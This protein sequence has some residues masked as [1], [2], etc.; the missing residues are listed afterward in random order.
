MRELERRADVSARRRMVVNVVGNGDGDSFLEDDDRCCLAGPEDH[1]GPCVR[2]CEECYGDGKC[3]D[4]HG[5][6]DLGCG[7][8]GGSGSCPAFCDDGELVDDPYRPI[9]TVDTGGLT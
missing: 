6:D 9:V 5:E 1:P 7:L 4:C 8:C 3:P 2:L